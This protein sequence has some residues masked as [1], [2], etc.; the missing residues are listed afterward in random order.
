[1]K[2]QG[3]YLSWIVVKDLKAAIK[4]YT[5][6]VGLELKEYHEQFQWAEL[7]GPAG[8]TLGIGQEDLK[9]DMKAGVNAIMTIAVE[10]LEKAKAH[11]INKGA[12]LVGETIEIPHHVKM[13]T[14]VDADGNT[15]QI[16][17]K[18]S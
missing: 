6:V 9:S 7:S 4:F 11:F 3:I 5:E 1:M 8:S 10:D 14:F 13:Q 18:L 17:E 16:V 12:N 15:M 2:T